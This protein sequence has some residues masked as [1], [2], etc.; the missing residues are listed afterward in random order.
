MV[1]TYIHSV[2]LKK[3]HIYRIKQ[4]GPLNMPFK[5][6][7]LVATLK[8][9]N[10]QNEHKIMNIKLPFVL[11]FDFNN[12]NTKIYIQCDPI[13]TFFLSFNLHLRNKFQVICLL[14]K[15]NPFT[16]SMYQ[17]KLTFNYLI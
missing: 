6:Y 1:N 9:K 10:V 13:K 3:L 2:G 5:V 16:Y 7:I 11:S 4:Y 14:M 12:K 15:I 8:L 17:Y